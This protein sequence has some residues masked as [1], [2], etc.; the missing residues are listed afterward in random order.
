MCSSDSMRYV[1]MG[2]WLVT[3]LVALSV[4]L[5]ALGIDV[6]T[7]LHLESMD[8]AVRYFAGLCGAYSLVMLF[9]SCC[10]SCRSCK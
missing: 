3:G 10:E 5:G 9:M 1:S 7:L 8:K 2:V 6:Q 4:G